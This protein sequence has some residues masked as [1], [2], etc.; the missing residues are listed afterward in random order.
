MY[1]LV[2]LHEKLVEAD[3]A[4][5][6]SPFG[7]A[8][9]LN[10]LASL[11]AVALIFEADRSVTRRVRAGLATLIAFSYT[12]LTGS[13]GGVLLVLT[14]FFVS[15]VRMGG[16]RTRAALGGGAL[17][18]ALFIG[19]LLA[20]NLAGRSF[21]SARAGA[22]QVGRL[23]ATYWLGAPVA[24]AQ[25]AKRPDALASSENIG[26][27]FL[28]TGRSLGMSI[29]IPG[30]NA[31]FTRIRP[32]G[33]RTN[34]YTIYFSYFKDYGWLGMIPLL[35]GV[36]ASLTLLWRLAMIGRPVA[37]LMYSLMCT[38][39]FRSIYAESFFLGL[40]GYIKAYL[41]Y[42]ALYYLLPFIGAI[43]AEHLDSDSQ[44][45]LGAID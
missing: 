18:V 44:P 19:G 31:R 29:D 25:I 5:A 7:I 38:A 20:V 35:A 12:A 32:D 11:V 24:F 36:G 45:S 13:K 4:N 43:R 8:G 40:N 2:A 14:L 39:I 37:I 9:N 42:C 23:T 6:S 21:D 1:L 33:S 16:I 10:V 26:R 30:L 28:Q 22:Q 15:Q 3:N 17:M 41:C 27:F 34:T